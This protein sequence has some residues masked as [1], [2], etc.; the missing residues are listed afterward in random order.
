MILKKL[1]SV[2]LIACFG[3][4]LMACEQ[5]IITTT[6]T[7]SNSTSATT[8]TTTTSTTS[9]Q[10]ITTTT[11][12]FVDLSMYDLVN[13]R[14]ITFFD[15]FSGDTLDATKWEH[16]IG[17]GTAY[18][19]GYW[20]NNEKQY[21][22]PEN[23]IV[24]DGALQIQVRKEQIVADNGTGTIMNYTSSR[25][26]TKGK[27]AQTYGRFEA[28]VRIDT[29]APGLWPAF[30]LLPEFNQYGNWP[31]SG[32]LDIM[33][34]RGSR[35]YYTTAATH[36]FD[37]RHTYISGEKRYPENTTMTDYHVYALEWTPT[38]ITYFVDDEVVVSMST[39]NTNVGDF[40]APFDQEFHILLNFAVGGNFDSNML[41]P[42]NLL[43]ATMYV[44]YIKVL[45][46][47][48][49]DGRK[50][51]EGTGSVY[52]TYD[53]WTI[54]LAD[55]PMDLEYFVF[56]GYR[57]DVA[58]YS[59]NTN[60]AV[61]NQYGRVTPIAPGTTIIRVATGASEALCEITVVE[62]DSD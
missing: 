49:I 51:P 54:S 26:R 53:Q 39:W 22:Q 36:Y 25:L 35:P 57:S 31:Y 33:E 61:V 43:P 59:S 55:G 3:F 56:N 46:F 47:D 40:P 17:T 4:V 41:P 8:T 48:D 16:M 6:T 14:I 15:D 1:L 19:L 44:D 23:T 11:E 7:I 9:T 32:E 12:P 5:T 52:L 62:E 42:D 30:W 50:A 38:K 29:A 45:A 2:C 24:Q 10:S 27:F 58:W 28:R 18:G 13:G 60:V 34:I 20:G 37:G 21:Y